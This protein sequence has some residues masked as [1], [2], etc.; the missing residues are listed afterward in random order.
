MTLTILTIVAAWGHYRV[1]TI[2]CSGRD[3][4]RLRVMLR[5]AL[6][7]MAFS[8]L[9]GPG[10]LA[11]FG[12]ALA[13]CLIHPDLRFRPKCPVLLLFL[14]PAAAI[15][16][17]AI[18]ATGFTAFAKPA[19]AWRAI[20][21]A[22]PISLALAALVIPQAG[23]SWRVRLV[24][25]SISVSVLAAAFAIE[26][27][28]WASFLTSGLAA[29]WRTGAWRD[30]FSASP[31]LK[32]IVA[33]VMLPVLALAARAGA[34]TQDA[35]DQLLI[36]RAPVS[37]RAKTD[38]ALSVQS[39]GEAGLSDDVTLVTSG[40]QE[41]ADQ[42]ARAGGSV[43]LR[44]ALWRDTDWIVSGEA[45]AGVEPFSLTSVGD[46]K[47]HAQGDLRLLV[48]WSGT[49]ADIPVYAGADAGWQ[50]RPEAFDDAGILALSAG[51]D[52][53]QD[54]QFNVHASITVDQSGRESSF[55]QAG[56][57]WRV[58]DWIGLEVGVQ[59]F[60]SDTGE[61]GTQAIAGLWLRF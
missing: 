51:I 34:W 23:F 29:V 15:S 24:I 44:V 57:L 25:A 6:G 28:I 47:R 61:T 41:T 14:M 55:A 56:L 54:L 27:L 39:Y 8:L 49:F 42:N 36:L 20:L 30:A 37:G 53:V 19:Q 52:L 1:L 58:D 11:A 13:A 50:F 26:P 18:G 35:G 46:W 9:L 45:G 5:I 21:D 17:V 32:P 22:A 38:S 7:F 4:L 43:R 3:L 33:I 59:A 48:G 12:T 60:E 2:L 10:G 16:M 31:A 40:Y